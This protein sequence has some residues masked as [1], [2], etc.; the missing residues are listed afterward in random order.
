MEQGWDSSALVNIKYL[1]SYYSATVILQQQQFWSKTFSLQYLQFLFSIHRKIRTG[2]TSLGLRSGLFRSMLGLVQTQHCCTMLCQPH[3]KLKQNCKTPESFSSFWKVY[4]LP[5]ICLPEKKKWQGNVQTRPHVYSTV[6]T[7]V[8]YISTIVRHSATTSQAVIKLAPALLS[9]RTTA[10]P[11]SMQPRGVLEDQTFC[12]ANMPC[13][14]TSTHFRSGVCV[15]QCPCVTPESERL[16]ELAR[17]KSNSWVLCAR[18]PWVWTSIVP[19]DVPAPSRV[20]GDAD[21]YLRENRL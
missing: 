2:A 7:C 21:K 1:G 9:R 6:L 19:V 11:L 8:S 14:T 20:C 16:R 18:L 15:F 12:T 5:C 17:T 4:H 13:S 10:L 3:H